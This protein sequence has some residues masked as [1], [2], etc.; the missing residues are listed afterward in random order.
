M[1]DHNPLRHAILAIYLKAVYARIRDSALKQ[2]SGDPW[3]SHVEYW[4]QRC[5]ALF[6]DYPQLPAVALQDDLLAEVGLTTQKKKR[7]QSRR[8]LTRAVGL[9]ANLGVIRQQLG[10]LVSEGIITSGASGYFCCETS[11]SKGIR[12]ARLRLY[13][14]GGGGRIRREIARLGRV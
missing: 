7:G 14:T 5:D 6:F 2:Q 4:V 9:G 3:R 12:Y 11:V 8:S 1:I 13:M 10:A